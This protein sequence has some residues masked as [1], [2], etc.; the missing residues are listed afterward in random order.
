M[1]C[2]AKKIITLLLSVMLL[3]S[4]V[5]T[6]V[7]AL[8]YGSEW[9]GYGDSNSQKYSDVPQSHW[10]YEAISRASSKNW[11]G[12]YPDGNFRPDG[13]ITRAEYF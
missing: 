7:F 12:G 13:S 2:K 10:A 3:L 5:S 1:K 8:G 4:T 6:T 9:A 11:F